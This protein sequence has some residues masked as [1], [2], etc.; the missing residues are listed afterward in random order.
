MLE[1]GFRTCNISK[2]IKEHQDLEEKNLHF[3]GEYDFRSRILYVQFSVV[4]ISYISFL[5]FS[6]LF[7]QESLSQP[8]LTKV[9]LR[10]ALRFQVFLLGSCL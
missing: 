6:F 1:L 5:H 7:P 4:K 10:L 2:A 9:T 3:L 8:A